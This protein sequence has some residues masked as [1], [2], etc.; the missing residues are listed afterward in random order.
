MPD[1]LFSL[2]RDA[3]KGSLDPVLDDENLELVWKWINYC[4]NR[5]PEC[6]NREL[7]SVFPDQ[8]EITLIDVEQMC[9][10]ESQTS[11]RY[12]ALSYVWGQ[13]PQYSAVIENVQFLHEP[14]SLSKVFSKIPTVIQNAVGLAQQLDERYLWVDS[15]CIVQDH[16]ATKHAQLALMAEIYNSATATI[17]ACAGA[18]ASAVLCP[19]RTSP[20]V[21]GQSIMKFT[22]NTTI[23]SWNDSYPYVF[24][25]GIF[26]PTN[27]NCVIEAVADSRYSQRGWTYQEKLL[28]RRRIYFLDNEIIFQCRLDMFSGN[29]VHDTEKVKFVRDYRH[30][31]GTPGVRVSPNQFE[32]AK[33]KS[34]GQGSEWPADMARDDWDKG[35]KFWSTTVEEYSKKEFTF[36]TDILDACAGILQAFQGY[37]SWA[38]LQGMP[39]P[40]FD[41]ALLWIPSTTVERR[42]PS[43]IHDTTV[44]PEFPSWSWLGWCGGVTFPLTGKK[45]YSSTL[46]SEIIDFEKSSSSVDAFAGE[47]VDVRWKTVLR[48]HEP[49]DH[50]SIYAS[51]LQEQSVVVEQS[52][53]FLKFKSDTVPTSNFIFRRTPIIEQRYEGE[54]TEICSFTQY[55]VSIYM[56]DSQECGVLF[57]LSDSQLAEFN[58]SID[59][60]EL[61]LLSESL[62]VDTTPPLLKPRSH[63]YTFGSQLSTSFPNGQSLRRDHIFIEIPKTGKVLNVMLISWKGEIAERVTIGQL[64]S[65]AWEECAN[66]QRKT[67]ILG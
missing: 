12:L 14:R 35:F 10:V 6:R 46:A 23:D 31:P 43:T 25:S 58:S 26:R 53:R 48:D 49:L 1:R 18:D 22:R 5:H 67:I 42:Q 57:G 21:D 62:P 55:Q 50:S 52:S 4:I 20:R 63:L 29:S 54:H 65:Q 44:N 17:I 45:P 51:Y 16:A 30:M 64:S 3:K 32:S 11:T 47:Q 15:L 27:T 19:T 36:N 34:R 39:E 7:A 2:R 41:L 38:I 13:T 33:I 37:S 61:V 60:L 8:V 56:D 66:V 9:L 59:H 40:L 24:D 28:S